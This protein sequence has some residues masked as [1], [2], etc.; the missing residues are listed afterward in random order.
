MKIVIAIVTT[1]LFYTAPLH[2]QEKGQSYVG[3]QYSITTFD[4]DDFDE[5]EPTAL[6][7]RLGHY[8]TD[9]ISIEGRLGFGLEDDDIE[10]GPEKIDIEIDKLYGIYGV[11]HSSGSN[12]TNV[13]G[14]VGYSKIELEATF[15]GVKFDGDDGGVS[16]GIGANY[17]GFNLEY[18]SYIREDDG[19]LSA[20]SLGYRHMFE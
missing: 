20:I 16:Y 4:L 7:L 5:T 15:L 1:V 19:D 6:V 11:L 8:M 17:H 12:D 13:Y 10:V 3:G 14:V 18:M 9:N 2:A